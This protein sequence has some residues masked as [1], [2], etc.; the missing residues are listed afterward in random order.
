MIAPGAE[1]FDDFAVLALLAVV[2]GLTEFL[3]VS[4][5]GHLV[6]VQEALAVTEPSLA[7]D[8]ALHLGTLAAVLVVYRRALR[9]LLR[10]ARR[11][12]WREPLLL[13]V[14]TLPVAV[15]GVFFREQ[16]EAAFGDPRFAAACMCVTAGILCVGEWGRRRRAASGAGHAELTF[17]RAL[18]IGVAQAFAVLPGISRSGTTIAVGLLLGLAPER[19]ARISFLASIPAILGAAALALPDLA[20]EEAGPHL[21]GFGVLAWSVL[22]AALVGWGALRLLLAFLGRGAFGWFAVYCAALGGGYLALA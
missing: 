20:A 1:S 9:D 2:Q 16:V 5:S 3:P 10:G 22:L 8:V 12:E 15:T 4:S 18:C 6:I 13:A 11:G 19:A 21:P 14:V 7:I 17:P